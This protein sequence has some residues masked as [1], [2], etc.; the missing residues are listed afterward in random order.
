MSKQKKK[1]KKKKIDSPMMD[2]LKKL[3]VPSKEICIKNAINDTLSYKKISLK[4]HKQQAKKIVNSISSKHL[5]DYT[6]FKRVK[7]RD[8]LKKYIH[9]E[10]KKK[11]KSKK[12]KRK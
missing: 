7:I 6:L 8:K 2:Y 3:P 4:K 5:A 11:D 12:T 10:I 9:L 1:H